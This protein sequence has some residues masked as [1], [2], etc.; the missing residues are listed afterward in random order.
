VLRDGDYCL[1]TFACFF[2]PNFVPPRCAHI[3]PFSVHSKTQTLAAIEMFTGPVLNAQI[4]QDNINHPSN[5]LNL[6]SNAHELMDKYLAWGIEAISSG[7]RWKYYYRIVRPDRVSAFTRLKDG[8][9]ISFGSGSGGDRVPL[10]DPRICNL[11]LAVS[12]VSYASGA[13]E[14]FDQFLDDEDHDGFQVPVYFGGPFVS[15]DVLMRRLETL[16]C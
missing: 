14:I 11:H 2:P 9:E 3:I 1:L 4:I 15:D 16:V 13:S 7:C 6:E 10:P 8:D 12:R 5:A